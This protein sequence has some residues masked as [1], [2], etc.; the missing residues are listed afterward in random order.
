MAS[1]SSFACGSLDSDDTRTTAFY[2]DTPPTYEVSFFPSNLQPSSFVPI[3]LRHVSSS[4]GSGLEGSTTTRV[5]TPTEV[6]KANE[7]RTTV[8]IRATSRRSLLD[9]DPVVSFRLPSSSADVPVVKG[10][11]VLNAGTDGVDIHVELVCASAS[12]TRA[13][14]LELTLLT[15]FDSSAA[16]ETSTL[17]LEVYCKAD[18]RYCSDLDNCNSR[19]LCINNNSSDV[20]CLCSP[21][22]AGRT[23]I[24]TLGLFPGPG[25]PT[26]A[27][28]LSSSEFT[29]LGGAEEDMGG[30]RELDAYPRVVDD[31]TFFVP[32]SETAR[33]SNAIAVCAG[34]YSSSVYFDFTDELTDGFDIYSAVWL[35]DHMNGA[36]SASLSS[37]SSLDPLTVL[38]AGQSDIYAPW[39]HNASST[40]PDHP[41]T[42]PPGRT[43]LY[44]VRT[45][46]GGTGDIALFGIPRNAYRMDIPPLPGRYEM[47]MGLFWSVDFAT[48]TRTRTMSI[49]ALPPHAPSCVAGALAKVSQASTQIPSAVA[50]MA[51]TITLV[52]LTNQNAPGATAWCAVFSA[53]G[54]CDG[55][56]NPA[57]N[58]QGWAVDRTVSTTVTDF[59][60]NLDV[61]VLSPSSPI[62]I[63]SP[64]KVV[65]GNTTHNAWRLGLDILRSSPSSL[66]SMVEMSPRSSLGSWSSFLSSTPSSTPLSASFAEQIGAKTPTEGPVVVSWKDMT[67]SDWKLP[68][69]APGYYGLMCASGCSTDPANP[70][71]GV[72]DARG[73]RSGGVLEWGARYGS[74]P[75]PGTTCYWKLDIDP[76]DENDENAASTAVSGMG[77]EIVYADIEETHEKLSFALPGQEATP[78]ST[79]V[80]SISRLSYSVPVPPGITSVMVMLTNDGMV[81]SGS[82]RLKWT[83]KGCPRGSF[84]TA[85]GT[86]MDVLAEGPAAAARAGSVW[87]T[88]APCAAGTSSS[89]LD[90]DTCELCSPGEYSNVPGST[91][92]SQ[93][94]L[95]T[96]APSAAS[97]SCSVCP[98]GQYSALSGGFE[99]VPCPPGLYTATNGSSACS[100]C[101]AESYTSLPGSTAC[102]AC[103]AHTASVYQGAVALSDCECVP[104][105]YHPNGT[106]GQECTLCPVGSFCEGGIIPPRA[107]YGSWA[108][109]EDPFVFHRCGA[110]DACP[111]GTPGTCREGHTGRLCSRCIDGWHMGRNGLCIACTG[112][113]IAA[114]PLGMVALVIL[115]FLF[116]KVSN[117]HKDDALE[118]TIGIGTSLGLFVSFAQ[119][120]E[121]FRSFN[122]N[123][124][125]PV[126]LLLSVFSVFS[127]DI[128]IFAPDCS[129]KTSY[130]ASIILRLALPVFVGVLFA[131]AHLLHPIYR[132]FVRTVSGP[133]FRAAAG[134]HR[135]QVRRAQLSRELAQ[136]TLPWKK[137]LSWFV[138]SWTYDVL[139]KASPMKLSR[140]INT[141]LA[142]VDIL[143]VYLVFSTFEILN[144]YAQY[145]GTYSLAADPS[146]V[147]Y[148]SVEWW[149]AASVSAVG[150]LV[151]VVLYPGILLYI[152][153]RTRPFIRSH[154]PDAIWA[155]FSALI[156]RFKRPVRYWAVVLVS[157]KSLVA[158]CGAI[159]GDIPSVQVA[160]SMMVLVLGVVAQMSW[161]PFRLLQHNTLEIRLLVANI[162]LLV[163]GLVFFINEVSSSTRTVLSIVAVAIILFGVYALLR[164]LLTDTVIYLRDMTA[165]EIKLIERVL[166]EPG[167]FSLAQ[168]SAIALS[169]RHALE[170]DARLSDGEGSVVSRARFF[171]LCHVQSVDVRSFG[172][173]PLARPRSSSPCSWL[174]SGLASC[175]S[176][177]K[178]IFCCCC[179]RRPRRGWAVGAAADAGKDIGNKSEADLMADEY[180]VVVRWSLD[181]FI[182]VE[183]PMGLDLFTLPGVDAAYEVSV[184]SPLGRAL[185][186]GTLLRITCAGSADRLVAMLRLVDDDMLIKI[187]GVAIQNAVTLL[188]AYAQYRNTVQ[189]VTPGL[190]KNNPQ[191]GKMSGEV[192]LSSDG[193]QWKEDWRKS[194]SSLT[195][196]SS[197]HE[198]SLSSS[199]SSSSSDIEGDASVTAVSGGGASDVSHGARTGTG[200]GNPA[201]P[202]SFGAQPELPMSPKSKSKDSG[203]PFGTG[204]LGAA[205]CG[206]G[207]GEAEAHGFGGL[208]RFPS[209]LTGS[210]I[211]NVTSASN[212]SSARSPTSPNAPR[213][214]SSRSRA[215]T[216]TSP[217]FPLVSSMDRPA[218]P[219]TT[220]TSPNV[221]TR[222]H[223]DRSPRTPRL[224]DD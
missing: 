68:A 56:T 113:T 44:A 194:T 50:N 23:C 84:T 136:T 176:F 206:G 26:G 16:V 162:A 9:A 185:L 213:S 86:K 103:P 46:S 140:S 212:V 158:L 178:R 152:H 180:G 210:A 189:G 106:T 171:E 128:Q 48:S 107:T 95:G 208:Q 167:S 119:Y 91:V 62:T 146:V 5:A 198:G 127:L 224:G 94:S 92:C 182:G 102:T 108:G 149:E 184:L 116:Y 80:S 14:R 112:T 163:C 177:V 133:K 7:Q 73:W 20:A 165:P 114:L 199:S 125:E 131:V 1:D 39:M 109:V 74:P 197:Q 141:F 85:L 64:T 24:S 205:V 99:C 42:L 51:A 82:F 89:L 45:L 195:S 81:A 220:P 221:P 4:V 61:S 93:C 22:Y 43:R 105:Y 170:S 203:S 126:L 18:F 169:R 186:T 77:L 52:S 190:S 159:F 217:N 132:W 37:S 83:A 160:S 122:V 130:V 161:R 223:S 40:D 70:G 147:C 222:R 193:K 187:Q 144:C 19:G 79:I 120:Q 209:S 10:S 215:D 38:Q 202:T 17:T 174:F 87:T 117:M 156:Y 118:A 78:F 219:T 121:V 27:D 2:S 175:F 104:G 36:S 60:S 28:W 98:P 57:T 15:S 59:A 71:R 145:D 35:S 53:R 29:D 181:E 188:H 30:I 76:V 47:F 41:G 191:P 32:I 196:L 139:T 134:K 96:F 138:K 129:I 179:S 66:R 31:D 25:G 154:V 166:A 192:V 100:R 21:P 142:V 164:V 88:C 33:E 155:R 58:V 211:L 6:A 111:G 168:V 72:V 218:D 151:Y 216:P 200:G 12:T 173:E 201:A 157:R 115:L 55:W 150:V 8:T 49:H 207:D 143:Y 3:Q 135:A 67:T 90:S 34:A 124:P 183:H 137:R 75:L 214:S 204:M 13:V 54:S 123:W 97:T 148:T 11:D 172:K 101:P 65:D 110:P 69:C 63:L 153:L